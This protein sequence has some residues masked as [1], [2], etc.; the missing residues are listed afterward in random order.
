[1]L[2]LLLIIQKVL[3]ESMRAARILLH[4]ELLDLRNLLL[5]LLAIRRGHDEVFQGL[6]LHGYG[7]ARVANVLFWV[8]CKHD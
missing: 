5:L 1:M 2:F 8:L 4:P 6:F 7:Q 3:D